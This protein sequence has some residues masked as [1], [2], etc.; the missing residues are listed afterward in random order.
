MPRQTLLSLF[1][2]QEGYVPIDEWAF[3]D[4]LDEY[5]LAEMREGK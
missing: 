5:A 4:A 2:I 3:R 1:G